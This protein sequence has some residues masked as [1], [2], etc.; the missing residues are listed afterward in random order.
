MTNP[1]RLTAFL[2]L[3]VSPWVASAQVLTTGPFAGVSL[4]NLPADQRSVIIEE[5]EDFQAALAGRLPPDAKL[6]A[7][8]ADGGTTFYSGHKYSLTI[9]MSLS[10]FGSL[11]GYIYGPVLVFDDAYPG[12]EKSVS[13]LRFYT[14]EQ[15]RGFVAKQLGP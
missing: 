3:A 10:S 15:L 6:K 4:T 7:A 14:R 2:L 13:N 11:S 5:S 1:A 8:A 12:D 9:R